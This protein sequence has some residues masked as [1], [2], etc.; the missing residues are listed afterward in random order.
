[1]GAASKL[2]FPPETAAIPVSSRLLGTWIKQ[3]A[4]KAQDITD[5]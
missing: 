3:I 2:W 1:V 5:P 4:I